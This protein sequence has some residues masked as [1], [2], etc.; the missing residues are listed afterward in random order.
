MTLSTAQAVRLRIQDIPAIFDKQLSFDGTAT[1]YAIGYLNTTSASAYVTASG[2]AAWTA[3]GAT[4]DTSGWVAF[5]AVQAAGVPFRV[6]GV[7]SVFSDEEIGQFTAV[8]GSVAGAA[9]EACRT[10]MFDALKRASWAAPDGTRYD[11]T[12]AQGHLMKMHDA[13]KAELEQDQIGDGGYVSWSEGQ[14]DW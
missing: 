1:Q 11:D 4:F 13:L 7:Y 3:T 5:S 6:R 9:L 2:G 10:L 12:Q 14:G 8:G